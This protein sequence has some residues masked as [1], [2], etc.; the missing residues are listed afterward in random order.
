MNEEQS[1]AM[2][3]MAYDNYREN[4]SHKPKY[5]INCKCFDCLQEKEKQE[6]ELISQPF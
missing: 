2:E 1:E 6:K 4:G 3:N 5:G